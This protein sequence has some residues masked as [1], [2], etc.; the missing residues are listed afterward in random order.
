MGSSWSSGTATMGKDGGYRAVAVMDGRLAS[1]VKGKIFFE[2]D[3]S[4]NCSTLGLN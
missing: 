4:F 3:V 1:P 2:Q